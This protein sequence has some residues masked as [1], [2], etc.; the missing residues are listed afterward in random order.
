MFSNF[1][2]V[3]VLLI[4]AAVETK[5]NSMLQWKRFKS[6]IPFVCTK[7]LNPRALYLYVSTM[8]TMP[9]FLDECVCRKPEWKWNV[10]SS[11]VT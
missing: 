5:V 4:A 10:A 11:Y 9:K 3:Y 2:R 8:K 6:F 1:L 7:F